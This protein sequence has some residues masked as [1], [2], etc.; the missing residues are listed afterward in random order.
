MPNVR[1][2]IK[3]PMWLQ[4]LVGAPPVMVLSSVCAGLA[5]GAIPALAQLASSSYHA[6][7]SSPILL[8]QSPQDNTVHKPGTSPN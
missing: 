5:G 1:R 3:G 2:W 6:A 4:F 7:T 8:H